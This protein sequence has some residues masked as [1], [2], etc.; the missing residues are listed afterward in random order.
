[1]ITKTILSSHEFL[2]TN[3]LFNSNC[4]IIH[5]R[6]R[7]SLIKIKANITKTIILKNLLKIQVMQQNVS[8]SKPRNKK[9]IIFF[10]NA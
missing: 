2:K 9:L 7:I 10:M 5:M 4:I 3:I 8:L 1:M 6:I